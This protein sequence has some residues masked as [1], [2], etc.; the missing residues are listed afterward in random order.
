MNA[1]INS[2]ISPEGKENKGLLP[3]HIMYYDR[4]CAMCTWYTKA[5]V[6]HGILQRQ[7]RQCYQQASADQE[8]LPHDAV[9]LDLD[10]ARNEIALFDTKSGQVHYGL[11]SFLVLFSKQ[12]P[13]LAPLFGTPWTERLIR[14]LYRLVS[15]NRK[16]ISPPRVF[17]EEGACTPDFKLGWRLAYLL[18]GS[19]ITAMILA[20]YALKLPLAADSAGLARE[21]TIC[22]GQLLFQG[23]IVRSIRRERLWHYLGNIVTISMVGA[24]GL[25]PVLLIDALF[26]LPVAVIVGHFVVVLFLMLKEHVRRVKYLQLPW[27][28]TITW[29]GYRFVLLVFAL[30]L[31]L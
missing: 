28:L 2:S 8:Y 19:L 17:E 11:R 22:L 20:A 30:Y 27:W 21:L 9:P 24:L 1:A 23:L 5:M 3:D 6:R 14:P 13:A 29:L 12:L 15:Y 16:V 18:I 7:G 31:Y 4:D 26:E 10:R 25:L